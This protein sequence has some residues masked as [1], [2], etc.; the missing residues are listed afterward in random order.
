MNLRFGLRV[1]EPLRRSGQASRVD[2]R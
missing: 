2:E 1:A